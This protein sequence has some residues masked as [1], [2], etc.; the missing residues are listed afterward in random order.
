VQLIADAKKT[1]IP[2][3]GHQV[4]FEPK[5]KELA[6]IFATIP[7]PSVFTFFASVDPNH[8]QVWDEPGTG[9]NRRSGSPV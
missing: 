7:T 5:A 2:E 3:C 9:A 4:F 6:E 8:Q 1:P